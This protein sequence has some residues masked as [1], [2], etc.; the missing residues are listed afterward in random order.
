[1]LSVGSQIASI[2][3][4]KQAGFKLFTYKIGQHIKHAR[5]ATKDAFSKLPDI[6]PWLRWVVVGLLVCMY[7]FYN[8]L[9]SN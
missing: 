4:A 7:L 2:P 1:M 5:Q 8:I 9:F 6:N 3:G